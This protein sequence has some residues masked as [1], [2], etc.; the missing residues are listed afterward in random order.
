MQC[1]LRRVVEV[2][3]YGA[4]DTPLANES[5]QGKIMHIATHALKQ[6][7]TFQFFY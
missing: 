3:R 5:M 2:L 4:G 6:L 7:P 1:G